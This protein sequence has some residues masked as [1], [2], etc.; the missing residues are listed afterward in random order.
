[1]SRNILNEGPE[2]NVY[3]NRDPIEATLPV[4]AIQP[5]VTDPITIS[6]KGLSG[7]TSQAGKVIKVNTAETALEY[8]DDID[9]EYTAG[10]QLNLVGTQFNLDTDIQVDSLGVGTY[11]DVGY[12][13]PYTA[14]FNGNN[15]S[16]SNPYL[17]WHF[18]GTDLQ[19]NIPAG[20][21]SGSNFRW[22]L[23]NTTELMRLDGNGLLSKL[24]KIELD[25]GSNEISNGTTNLSIGSTSG[26]I[27]VIDDIPF[28]IS[29]STLTADPD[30]DGTNVCTQFTIS[31]GAGSNGDCI[32][33]IQ[34]DTDDAV[35]TSNPEIRLRAD[36]DGTGTNLKQDNNDF[37]IETIEVGQN[38]IINPA[39]T[40]VDI[41]SN[42]KAGSTTDNG[43]IEIQHGGAASEIGKLIFSNGTN[44]NTY[45]FEYSENIDSFSFKKGGAVLWD[46]QG[47]AP[48]EFTVYPIFKFGN[49]VFRNISNYSITLPTP[50]Q[51]G[52]K[53]ALISDITAANLWTLTSNDLKPTSTSY[54]VILGKATATTGNPKLDVLGNAVIDGD[55]TMT[56][57]LQVED[58]FGVNHSNPYTTIYDPTGYS[59]SNPYIRY[60]TNGTDLTFNL[61]NP[62]GSSSSFRFL[63]GMT[64]ELMRMDDARKLKIFGT[65]S[66]KIEIENN[67]LTNST[68]TLDF[69]NSDNGDFYRFEYDYSQDAFVFIHNHLG[70]DADAI[71]EYNDSTEEFLI[72][73]DTII[74]N[75]ENIDA[76]LF[77]ECS[78][79]SGAEAKLIFGDAYVTDKYTLQYD[80]HVTDPAFELLDQNLDTVFRYTDADEV[81]S[82][83]DKVISTSRF[84]RLTGG[85]GQISNGSQLFSLP[86]TSGTLALEGGGPFN[87]TGSTMIADPLGDNSEVCTQFIISSGGGANGDC[88]LLIRADTDNTVETSNPEI[89]FRADGGVTGANI[90]MD[91]N[92]LIIETT[93]QDQ[94]IV[95]IPDLAFKVEAII[96]DGFCWLKQQHQNAYWDLC[97]DKASATTAVWNFRNAST[98]GG[99]TTGNLTI[100]SGGTRTTNFSYSSSDDRLKINEELIEN[101]TETIMKLRPQK[102]DKYDYLDSQYEN[103]PDENKGSNTLTHEFG[104]IAQEIYYECPELR[105]IVSVPP[106]AT[107]IDN[108]ENMNFEDIQNDP[109]YSNWGDEPASIHYNSFIPL[110]T[111]GFQEQQTIIQSQQEE[112][113]TLKQELASIKQLLA[114]LNIS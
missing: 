80:Y 112:I 17:R 102:Y 43:Q 89:R 7:F 83:T 36:N 57:T 9:T 108:N 109:D 50:T 98:S 8:A 84:I 40:Y 25:G 62:Q 27:A 13:N 56:G 101:A 79:T 74:R 49:T 92:D 67:G 113:N 66:G 35:E 48:E 1:M 81:F 87:T 72:N 21:G 2:V 32:L 38:I 52:E 24:N 19:F 105:K 71:W 65:T 33:L 18:N 12:S 99:Y 29:G 88:V 20:T 114:N 107:L 11:F 85:A 34:A 54:N 37:I 51:N 77:I 47:S 91:N 41:Q 42:L 15:Y 96:N 16:T 111:K 73:K 4:Q 31:S 63:S 106:S 69:T 82:F 110:L 78:E 104:F 23:Q 10:N 46:Y 64:N 97:Y 14:I 93:Y 59:T 95:I 94:D 68:S 26:T 61:P 39:G 5:T 100:S 75:V 58:H 6:L 60:H 30:G 76:K 86:S 44:N 55:I 70:T 3:L 90:K 22:F 53:L 45:S 28:S 103:M